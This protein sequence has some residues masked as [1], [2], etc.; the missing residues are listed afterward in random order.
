MG[1]VIAMWSGLFFR[2]YGYN[3]YEILILLC[4]VMG[5]GID[6]PEPLTM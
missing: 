3:F 2:K 4:F 5:M 1:I 6:I